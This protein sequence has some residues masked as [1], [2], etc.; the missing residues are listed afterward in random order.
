MYSSLSTQ[1]RRKS[2]QFR[3]RSQERAEWENYGKK[4]VRRP[5]KRK[6]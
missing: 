1:N 3:E 2:R 6:E 4:I 5:V